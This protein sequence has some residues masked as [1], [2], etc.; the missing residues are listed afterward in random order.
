[1]VGKGSSSASTAAARLTE[2][3]QAAAEAKATQDAADARAA[4]D[5]AKAAADDTT[6]KAT[7][8]L[9]QLR[10][11]ISDNKLE[12]AEGT[13]QQLNGMKGSLPASLVDKIEAAQLAMNAQKA[14]SMFG[15]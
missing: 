10:Q 2:Q 1:M 6:A 13:L 7:S 4:A 5:A 8:L 15:K 11:Y 9:E 14:N 12:L 3:N